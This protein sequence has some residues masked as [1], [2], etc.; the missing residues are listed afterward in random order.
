MAIHLFSQIH[1]FTWNSIKHVEKLP[2]RHLINS[3]DVWRFKCIL[4]IRCTPK[5]FSMNLIFI[6]QSDK[7]TP[8]RALKK[9]EKFIKNLESECNGDLLYMLQSNRMKW[10][11]KLF[12]IRRG[13]CGIFI[14]KKKKLVLFLALYFTVF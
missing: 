5:P 11:W 14:K 1:R 13:Q 8:K 12:K 10:F 3:F 7:I 6:S 9:S 2:R 4:F